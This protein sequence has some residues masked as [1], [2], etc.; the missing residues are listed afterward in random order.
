[1]PL[2]SG[3]GL[4][5]GEISVAPGSSDE[6]GNVVVS[7]P[8]GGPAC[9][10][11]VAAD[12]TAEYER[13]GGMPSVTAA[14]AAL[15]IPGMHGLSAGPITVQ[16]G[17]SEEHGNVE[18]SCPA[19]GA[20]CVLIV[21]ADGTAEYE[22]TGG[23]PSVMVAS[24]ALT[25]PGMHGL[26]AGPIT[27]Q[28]G[29]SE[30]HGN[31]EVSCPAGGAACVLIVAADGTAEYERTGGMP[32]VTAASESLAMPYVHGLPTGSITVQP[33]TSEEH[34]NVILSCPAD[35]RACVMTVATD[36]MV[37]FARTGGTPTYMLI[38]GRIV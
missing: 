23:M 29:T 37:T 38:I 1:M 26:S 20:A 24:A 21:A 2:P 25:I 4:A 16:P 5:A 28:P 34:D 31:V 36:G 3:H 7:C 27:V 32:S 10:L 8:A 15:T 9:V 13:T 6:H 17:T 30:E 35:G 19:G 33:G 12:G 18:V 11:I 14:S 22:R